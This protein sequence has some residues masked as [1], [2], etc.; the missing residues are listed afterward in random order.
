MLQNNGL[1]PNAA[2]RG[3]EA[4]YR[5]ARSQAQLI[6]DLLDVS[7]IITGKLLLNTREVLLIDVLQAAIETMRP[8]IEA[9]EIDLQLAFTETPVILGDFDRLQQV[10][11]NLISNAVKFTSQNGKI[12]VRL[13]ALNS[14]AQITVSDTGKGI[15]ASFLP[16][17]FERFRQADGTTTRQYG[18]LGLGLAIVRHIVELHGGTVQVS[19]DGDDRGTNFIVKLP[20]FINSVRSAE[21]KQAEKDDNGKIFTVE[22][23]NRSD[24]SHKINGLRVLLVDD[25][26]DTLE[27]IETALV[28]C[29]VEVRFCTSAKE[30]LEMTRKWR[31]DI[32]VS[33]IAMPDA[34]GYWLIKELRALPPTEGGSIPVI[35]LTAYGRVEDRIKALASGFQMYVPKPIEPNELLAALDNLARNDVHTGEN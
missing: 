30:G 29:K 15:G 8:A 1:D 2:N 26:I 18:G 5:N 32:L 35:A 17:V 14:H 4:I 3:M 23:I 31:P 13:E 25:E 19:S 6:D 20:L 12:E 27:M 9:K 7:R 16:Y 34:D 33:D 22:N 10:F 21:E 24:Y 11:W 28:R